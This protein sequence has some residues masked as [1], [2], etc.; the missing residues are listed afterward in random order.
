[1]R[2]VLLKETDSLTILSTFEAPFSSFCSH[3]S[4]INL[5]LPILLMLVSQQ[6]KSNKFFNL[7]ISNKIFNDSNLQSTHGA[8]IFQKIGT[9]FGSSSRTFAAFISSISFR[10]P[11]LLAR[12]LFV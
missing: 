2:I 11:L 5:N 7:S 8:M 9:F 4:F 3:E 10:L 6:E 1:M 12:L